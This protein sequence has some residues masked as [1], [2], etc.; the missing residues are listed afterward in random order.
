MFVSFPKNSNIS[1]QSM[2]HVSSI[3][4]EFD[5]SGEIKNKCMVAGLKIILKCY[6]FYINKVLYLGLMLTLCKLCLNC[7]ACVLLLKIWS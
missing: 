7:S 2:I 1:L 5:I 3:Y 4:K 6:T